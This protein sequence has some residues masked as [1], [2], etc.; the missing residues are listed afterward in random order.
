M[1]FKQA[2][3]RIYDRKINAG[4]ITFSQTGIKKDDFTRL[5]TEEDFL[6]DGETL[7]NIIVTM[8]L[9]EAEKTMLFDTLEEDVISK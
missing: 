1:T 8:K 2:F 5:C 6:F 4:E 9:T 7:E 3:F